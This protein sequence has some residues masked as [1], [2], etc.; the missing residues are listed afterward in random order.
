MGWAGVRVI[1]HWDEQSYT[2][3]PL[4]EGIMDIETQLYSEAYPWKPLIVNVMKK[5]VNGV[6]MT[7]RSFGAPTPRTLICK[8]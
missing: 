3:A 8:Y 2:F 7:Y 1:G 6:L 5:P 4:E